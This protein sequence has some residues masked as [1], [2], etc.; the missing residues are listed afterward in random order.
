M[1]FSYD[2]GTVDILF[3]DGDEWNSTEG[4]DVLLMLEHVCEKNDG[5]RYKC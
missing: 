4:K 1:T 5:T 3:D 2:N